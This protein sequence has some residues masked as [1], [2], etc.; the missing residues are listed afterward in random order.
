MRKEV[1][2]SDQTSLS[3]KYAGQLFDL[4]IMD[5]G[6]RVMQAVRV[7]PVKQEGAAHCTNKASTPVDDW[8]RQYAVDIDQYNAWAAGRPPYSQRVRQW[9]ADRR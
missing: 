1:G 8:A 6:C 9:R 4:Q 7:M 5:D 3:K 2:A